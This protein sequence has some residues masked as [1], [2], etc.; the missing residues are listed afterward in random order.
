[1]TP[2]RRHDREQP[3]GALIR[4]QAG[5]LVIVTAPAGRHAVGSRGELP[6]PAAARRMC[7]IVAGQPLLLAP[8]L[9]TTCW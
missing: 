1:M 7:G 2:T 3:I 6:L 9:L 4:L 8:F 5:I